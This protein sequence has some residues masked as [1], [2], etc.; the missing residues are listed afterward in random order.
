MKSKF[1]KSGILIVVIAITSTASTFAGIKIRQ[2][3]N[4]NENYI[5][6]LAIPTKPDHAV[7]KGYADWVL[8]VSRG[9]L[10]KP[11]NGELDTDETGCSWPPTR[12]IDNGDNTVLDIF[13]GLMWT[14]DARK[15]GQFTRGVQMNYC[16]DLV[17]AGYDDWRLPNVTELCS[18]AN[19]AKSKV[20]VWLNSSATPFVNVN[21]NY[22]S[23]TGGSAGGYIWDSQG[24]YSTTLGHFEKFYVWPVR[25]GINNAL[26]PKC[27]PLATGNT[28]EYSS[29]ADVAYQAGKKWNP[30]LGERFV[31]NR[32]SGSEVAIEDRLTKLIWTQN[33]NIDGQKTWDNAV[34]YCNNLNYG[35]YS[36]WRLPNII[37]IKSVVVY[38][39]YRA[40]LPPGHPFNSV[41]VNNRYWTSTKAPYYPSGEYYWYFSLNGFAYMDYENFN[42][43]VWPV[44]GGR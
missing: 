29:G 22:W 1:L 17:F 7:P 8:N 11:G 32:T 9:I 3:I 39:Y 10:P 40:H 38:P 13:T 25:L 14:K 19:Y 33:V 30:T 15:N 2:E 18:L 44:R 42:H 23:S 6:N 31:T 5:T 12:F 28:N 43:Y 26:T 16:E 20:M 36:D 41:N 34:A 21:G 35:G 37:E 24:G 27:Q 4:M